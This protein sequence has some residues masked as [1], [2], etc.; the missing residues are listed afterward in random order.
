[1]AETLRTAAVQL[2]SDVD[3]LRNLRAVEQ[4][5]RRAVDLGARLVALPENFAYFGP[6]RDRR[7]LA[8]GLGESGPIQD[9]LRE[10]AE[11]NRIYLLGGGFPERSDDG[12][13]PFNTSV[14]FDPDGALAAS[15]RKI[16][17]FD[18][19][20]PSGQ[21]L[22]ESAGTSAG[23]DV[24]VATV[25]GFRVGLSIC[26]DLRFSRLYDRLHEAGAEILTVPAAFTEQTGKDHWHVLLRA[27]AIEWQCWVVAPGQWGEHPGQ[28]RSYGHS[29]IV[30][31]WGTVVAQCSQGVGVCL[32]DVSR[33]LLQ[34]VR[35]R[36]PRQAQL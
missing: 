21:A 14:L 24:V 31:P 16:H 9:C 12:Q 10:L 5:V 13:R 15:Y 23:S 29:L 8:E 36:M 35:Q 2:Q 17:L 25:D 3:L 32:V 4:Q 7:S 20:L 11:K 1:M 6:E 27:R 26:Y 18:V 33:D 28:R 22:R 34:E 30:D 19:E